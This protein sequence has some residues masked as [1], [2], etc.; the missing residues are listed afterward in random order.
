MS[1]NPWRWTEPALA[2]LLALGLIGP[3]LAPEAVGQVGVTWVQPTNAVSWPARGG[4]AILQLNNKVWL[5]GGQF[6]EGLNAN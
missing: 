5:M 4:P 1:I 2:L 6:N 3:G